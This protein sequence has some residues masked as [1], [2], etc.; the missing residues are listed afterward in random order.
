M[1][2]EKITPTLPGGRPA[3]RAR[4][5]APTSLTSPAGLASLASPAGP[6]GPAGPAKL[7]MV[8]CG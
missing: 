8:P 3:A 7:K 6:A 2:T 4:A 1:V 5:P